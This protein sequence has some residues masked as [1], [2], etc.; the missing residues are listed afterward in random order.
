MRGNKKRDEGDRK[1]KTS[2]EKASGL[3]LALELSGPLH[4][5]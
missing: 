4:Q 1:E 5:Q 3:K 2:V